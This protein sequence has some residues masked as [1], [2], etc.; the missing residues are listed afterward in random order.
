MKPL[1]TLEMDELVDLLASYSLKY[2]TI[3]RYLGSY[4]KINKYKSLVE[5]LMNEIEKRKR[6]RIG[7]YNYITPGHLDDRMKSA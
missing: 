6:A 4:R 7:P 3:K 5:S 2:S 1:E